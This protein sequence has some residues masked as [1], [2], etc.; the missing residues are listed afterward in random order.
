MLVF[1]DV[2]RI[3]VLDAINL[4]TKKIVVAQAKVRHYLQVG[5]VGGT[6]QPAIDSAIR[7][8]DTERRKSPHPAY[9]ET[10]YFS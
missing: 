3:P 2:S 6:L 5:D 10:T 9:D 7:Q 1:P 4:Q 8:H